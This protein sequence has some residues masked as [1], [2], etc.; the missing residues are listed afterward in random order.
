MNF[1]ELSHLQPGLKELFREA[2][3]A[4]KNDPNFCA[5]EMYYGY[6]AFRNNGG[7]KRKILVLVGWDACTN[8][9]TL[10]SSEAYDV[11]VETIWNALPPCGNQCGY[12]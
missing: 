4:P 7:L 2:Q 5:N 11:V 1:A 9:Q 8:H 3:Q 10:L 12:T 6:G